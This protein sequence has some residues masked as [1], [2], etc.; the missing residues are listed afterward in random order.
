MGRVAE[1]IRRAQRDPAGGC[2]TKGEES[3]HERTEMTQLENQ[4]SET[5]DRVVRFEPKP[6]EHITEADPLG[7]SVEDVDLNDLSVGAHVIY[8][9]LSS[10]DLA[11]TTPEIFWALFGRPGTKKWLN[12]SIR[13][14]V[15]IEQGMPK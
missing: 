15:E 6:D 1:G 3:Q 12:N 4:Q 11:Q 13:K 8:G 7:D 10:I 2:A 9:S 14:L 5:G